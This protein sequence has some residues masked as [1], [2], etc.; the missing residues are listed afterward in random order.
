MSK[1]DRKKQ[2]QRYVLEKFIS[3]LK[4]PFYGI[5]E[6]E[7]PDFLLK[8]LLEEKE[9]LQIGI[10]L[11][12]L[13]NPKLKK[14]EAILDTL[15]EYSRQLFK[16]VYPD[17]NLRV[18]IDFEL[19]NHPKKKSEITNLSQVLFELISDVYEKNSNSDFQIRL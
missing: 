1:E 15:I 7:T 12:D 9:D 3:S 16:K 10:E 11:I 19:H 8:L 14:K 2:R 17:A 18:F 5:E 4:M 13:I 6:N